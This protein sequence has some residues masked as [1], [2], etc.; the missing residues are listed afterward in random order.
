[1]LGDITVP[2]MER[3]CLPACSD[4]LIRNPCNKPAVSRQLMIGINGVP[5]H[6]GIAGIGSICH[7]RSSSVCLLGVI[8]RIQVIIYCSVIFQHTWPRHEWS[9]CPVTVMEYSCGEIHIRAFIIRIITVFQC[10]YRCCRVG[11]IRIHLKAILPCEAE[12][13]IVCCIIRYQNIGCCRFLAVC[14]CYLQ[15]PG[16]VRDNVAMA[17]Q[18][19]QRA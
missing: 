19:V 15:P 8:I 9:V 14:C 5:F 13:N 12:L 3:P 10:P 4:L 7:I 18:S 16:T 2:L 6:H 1:M 11:I 17:C